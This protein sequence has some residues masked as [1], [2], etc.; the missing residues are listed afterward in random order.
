MSKKSTQSKTLA[1]AQ[2]NSNINGP[3]FGSASGSNVKLTIPAFTAGSTGGNITLN[4]P[5]YTEP[6]EQ[7]ITTRKF[8]ELMPMIDG[9]LKEAYT[10][11]FREGLKAGMEE[12]EKQLSE[13]LN[14]DI[15]KEAQ[16]QIQGPQSEATI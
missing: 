7:D 15:I 8:N 16:S 3:Y 11:G 9:L 10:E 14:V 12:V 2:T 13:I 5:Y 1:S 6:T 4:Q